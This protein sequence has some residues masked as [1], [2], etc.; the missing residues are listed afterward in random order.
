[1]PVGIGQVV[2]RLFDGLR[3]HLAIGD[4]PQEAANSAGS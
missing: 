2:E 4:R 3:A 1:M